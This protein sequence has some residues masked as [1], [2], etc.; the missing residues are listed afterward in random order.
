MGHKSKLQSTLSLSINGYWDYSADRNKNSPLFSPY[1]WLSK[2]KAEHCQKSQKQFLQ[3]KCNKKEQS[4]RLL[5]FYNSCFYIWTQNIDKKSIRKCSLIL[6]HNAANKPQQIFKNLPKNRARKN[7][8]KLPA[9][10]SKKTPVF[11]IFCFRATIIAPKFPEKLILKK[12][13]TIQHNSDT[14]TAFI[15]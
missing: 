4:N 14:C 5:F 13:T 8:Q 12:V 11:D 9:K 2:E 15:C 3:E 1:K 10:T 7:S 6:Y